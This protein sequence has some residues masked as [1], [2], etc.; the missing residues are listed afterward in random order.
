MDKPIVNLSLRYNQNET[1]KNY[2]CKSLDDAA[3]CVKIILKKEENVIFWK[4][5]SKKVEARIFLLERKASCVAD[6]YIVDILKFLDLFCTHPK[7][8][9]IVMSFHFFSG[10]DEIA[11]KFLN[12]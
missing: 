5:I 11:R 12:S 3:D 2:L 7:H 6:L 8:L 4:R 10:P 1:Y 9:D